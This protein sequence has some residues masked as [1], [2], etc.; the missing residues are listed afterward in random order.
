M[1]GDALGG[2]FVTGHIDGTVTVSGLEIQGGCYDITFTDIQENHLPCLV[3]KGSVTINGVSLTI[4]QVTSAAFNVTLIP[5]TIER[6]N[7]GQLSIGKLVNIEYDILSKLVERQFQL[8]QK[9]SDHE[10][11]DN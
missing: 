2:H 10:T 11:R 9:G 1:A 5:E 6:T 8:R 4:N 7:L 3:E